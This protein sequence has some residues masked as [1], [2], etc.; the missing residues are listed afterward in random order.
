MND[1]NVKQS[2]MPK[3]VQRSPGKNDR[4]KSD[5]GK[6]LWVEFD[7]ATSKFALESEAGSRHRGAGISFAGSASLNAKDRTFSKT[8]RDLMAWKAE[9][10]NRLLQNFQEG[11]HDRGKKTIGGWQGTQST[12]INWRYQLLS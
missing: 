2:E 6:A 12:R 4:E 7:K 10:M 3:R 1:K 5:G 11:K 8:G 9:V